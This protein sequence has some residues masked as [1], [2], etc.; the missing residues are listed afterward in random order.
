MTQTHTTMML[1]IINYYY[2]DILIWHTYD[3]DV[4]YYKLQLCSETLICLINVPRYT[5][6]SLA[7]AMNATDHINV[8]FCKFAYSFMNRVIASPIVLETHY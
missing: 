5:S 6:S 1:F 8:V 3:D 2:I 7:F 4:I